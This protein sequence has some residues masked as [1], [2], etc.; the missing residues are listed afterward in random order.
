MAI[1]LLSTVLANLIVPV[2]LERAS[3]SIP[4]FQIKKLGLRDITKLA[5]VTELEYCYV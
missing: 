1:P 5:K 2:T 4:I 3:M